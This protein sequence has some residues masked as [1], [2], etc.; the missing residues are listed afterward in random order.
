M[1]EFMP[2]PVKVLETKEDVLEAINN[3]VWRNWGLDTYHVKPVWLCELVKRMW[4]E[5]NEILVY[6]AQ[7]YRRAR[8]E[9]GLPE[10]DYYA[11]GQ[12]TPLSTLVFNAQNYVRSD[13][14][15]ADGFE[16]MTQELVERAHREKK[17]ILINGN[18]AR[19]KVADGKVVAY[20]PR[21]RNKAY[22]VDYT[23][24]VKL[25]D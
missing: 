9:L 16:P 3:P 1:S 6:N 7:V 8:E 14:L 5:Q 17:R 25:V 21:T 4:Q 12:G 13:R 24:P 15:R 23:T 11:E 22:R 20:P 10:H 19:T 18:P 2:E